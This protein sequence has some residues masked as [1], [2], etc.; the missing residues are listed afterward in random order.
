MN[1]WWIVGTR[2]FQAVGS[3]CRTT[4]K[5]TFVQLVTDVTQTG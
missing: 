3:Q 5:I 2:Q 4:L 1:C